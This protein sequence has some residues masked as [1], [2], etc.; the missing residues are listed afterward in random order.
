MARRPTFVLVAPPGARLGGGLLQPDAGAAALERAGSVLQLDL[1][2]VPEERR[3]EAFGEAVGEAD[4]VVFAPWGAFGVGELSPA[5]WSAAERLRVIAGTFDN[6]FERIFGLSLAQVSDRGITVVDTSRSMTPTVA[7]F[8]LAMILNL[9]RDIPAAVASMRAGEWDVAWPDV[10]GAVTGDLSGRRVGLAG[11]G[12]ICRR[13]ADLLAP[14]A[15][16]LRAFDPYVGADDLAAAG[17]GRADSLGELAAWSE[18][19]VVGIPP[20]PATRAIIDAAVIGALPRGSLFV[21]PTRMAVVDQKALW[22]R[23]R[24]GEL[25]AA[26]DVYDPEPPAPEAPFRTDRNVLPTPHMAGNTSAA[27][28]RCFTTACAEAVA[29]LEGRGLRYAMTPV[30]AAA[31]AGR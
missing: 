13:L 7:E 5:C 10:P 17:V 4:A 6:R 26:V 15:C 28:H 16:E 11:F 21:L 27:H 1:P 18:I 20:T 2:A 9:L 29:A 3:A 23:T 8:A 31:Y 12:V 19:F 24:A 14:F 25:R 22:A 30:D